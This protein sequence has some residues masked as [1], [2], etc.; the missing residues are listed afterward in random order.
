MK[1]AA[2]VLTAVLFVAGVSLVSL[3]RRGGPPADE[4]LRTSEISLGEELAVLTRRLDEALDRIE[5]LEASRETARSDRA[6][7]LA[8]PEDATGDPSTSEEA[9]AAADKASAGVRRDLLAALAGEGEE[10]L[11]FREIVSQAID[12][13][14]ARRREEQVRRM[15][16]RKREIEE[17]NQGPYEKYNFRVNTIG[18]KLN[19]SETQK[20]R[21]YELLADYGGRIDEMRRTV[22][23]QDPEAY[24]AYRER[25]KQTEEEFDGLVIQSLT[26]PQAEAYKELPPFE[27]TPGSE[28]TVVKTAPV[29]MEGGDAI[30]GFEQI[31]YSKDAAGERVE[32]KIGVDAP[33]GVRLPPARFPPGVGQSAPT[34]PQVVK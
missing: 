10:A 14:R 20:A 1:V 13:D 5:R 34:A 15:E 21:Y 6:A 7:S 19:L 9:P 11:Q 31:F 16:D 18:K 24:K 8:R 29:L 32:V 26:Y 17:L 22:N 28:A 23:R 2:L 12:H 3:T 4:S 27:R 33:E 30:G 25:R